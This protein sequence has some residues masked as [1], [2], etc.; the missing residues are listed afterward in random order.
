MELGG[1]SIDGPRKDI[2][3]VFQSATLTR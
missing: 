1:N 3:F 2:G